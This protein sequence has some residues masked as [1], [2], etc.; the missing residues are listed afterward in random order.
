[1]NHSALKYLVSMMCVAWVSMLAAPLE[2]GEAGGAMEVSYRAEL[3]E[4]DL[5]F[6]T[7][8]G[9]DMVEI[10]DGYCVNETGRP[11][12][13]FLNV[14]VALPEGMMATG[15]R[16]LDMTE[17]Q[18]PGEYMIF[19]AQP[20]RHTSTPA[21]RVGFVD[22]DEGAYSSLAEYPHQVVELS[23]QTD[24]AGQAMVALKIYPLRYVPGEKSLTLLTSIDIIIEGEDGYVCG[25]YLPA[26]VSDRGR[27]MYEEMVDEMVANPDDVKLRVDETGP[28]PLGVS[29]GN[30]E[31]VIITQTSWLDDFQPLAD[32]KTKKGVSAAVVD[33]DWI[34]GE[35]SGSS[36]QAKIRA[37][38]QDAHSNWG[39]IYFLL[40]GD[41]SFI[42]YYT[43]SNSVG[44]VPSDT[45]YGDYDSDWICEVHVGRA[46]VRNTTEIG[47]FIG[48]VLTYEQSPPLTS[49]A[50]EIGMFGFDLYTYG[51][52]EG[53]DCKVAIGNLY[54]PSGWTL[55]EVYDSDSGNHRT[56]SINEIN[57]GHNL[58]NHIDHSGTTFMGLGYTNH[59]QGIYNGDADNFYNGDKESIFYSIGC[60]PAAYDADCIAEHFVRNSNG[61]G[62][63]FVGNPRYGWY[64][65]WN[66]DYYS[67]RYDRYFF[68]SL[69][70]QGHFILGDCFSDHKNDAYQSDD[71]YRYIF[72]ELT[73]LGDPELPIWTEDPAGFDLVS[74]PD[75][76]GLGGQ[77]FTVE[78][79]DN[80]SGVAG[81]VV[82]LLK[83]T[84]VY[85]VATT[86][87]D[88]RV[89]L[90][91]SPVSAGSMDVTVTGRNYIP[92]E[93]TCEVNGP[94][95][96]V[97]LVLLPDTTVVP[98]GG[99]LGYTV[100]AT[101]NSTSSV[102]I[103]YWTDIE[104]WNGNPYNGNPVFG[105]FTATIDPSS[106][107]EGHL[108]QAVPA[109][110]PLET[111]TCYGRIGGHPN[112]V[113]A[114]SSFSFTIVDGR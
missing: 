40:G 106:V 10:K 35:Y 44:S 56:N 47:T 39:A 31:Y 108:N 20:L 58:L 114:E 74:Y 60:D 18:L 32:W 8:Q 1:M 43:Y 102:T 83:G 112:V 2:A 104:L 87:V 91:I 7:V 80:G 68:R 88:G 75:S 76:I 82:C 28:R 65:P 9:Y 22:P 78:V 113:W 98:R 11:M 36:N 66:G 42:P 38:V 103:E 45:Y 90:S 61:G 62:V 105:P 15:I 99:Y 52:S 6:S 53:E 14:A 37:F 89:T 55:S 29:P 95:P 21:E 70:T 59:G 17:K 72:Q 85:E 73:L 13:P 51:S 24:L 49:Y 25:D 33:R 41:T 5:V 84:D 3:S 101:N 34:Y 97:S 4:G 48:K 50:T 63:A 57:S 64:S 111:Y 107:V 77:D 30:Y 26:G 92:S 86:G 27:E 100:T 19:P 109:G 93:G 94:M 71:T 46:S 12:M 54:V 67:L 96:D 81:A 69:F 110:A 79:I 23:D 16:V